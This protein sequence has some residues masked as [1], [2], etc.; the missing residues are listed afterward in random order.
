MLEYCNLHNQYT[1]IAYKYIIDIWCH[2]WH[3]THAVDVPVHLMSTGQLFIHSCIPGAM[4]KDYNPNQKPV[5]LC[6]GC[7]AGGFRKCQRTSEDQYY[8]ASGAFRCLVE[9]EP[10]SVNLRILLPFTFLIIW[11]VFYYLIQIY[12]TVH[13]SLHYQRQE[14]KIIN[15]CWIMVLRN[16]IGLIVVF[17]LIIKIVTFKDPVVISELNWLNLFFFNQRVVILP[18]WNI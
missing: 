7:A 1:C 15:I 4:D 9:S 3:I 16:Q 17:F 10:T 12:T 6:E 18:L 2:Q 5:S 14:R 11:A 13:C 8:S